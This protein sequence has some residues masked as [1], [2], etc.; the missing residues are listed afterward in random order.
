MT[1]RPALSFR[2]VLAKVQALTAPD[3]TASRDPRAEYGTAARPEV[4]I[5]VGG[6]LVPMR[7]RE[8]ASGPVTMRSDCL[9]PS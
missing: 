8:T 9:P 1:G 2:G 5:S 3:D 4:L 6:Q 7:P